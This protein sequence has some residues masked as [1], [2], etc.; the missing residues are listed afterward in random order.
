M[1]G[2]LGSST[3]TTLFFCGVGQLAV[4]IITCVFI[5]GGKEGPINVAVFPLF[6]AIGMV[7][8]KFMEKPALSEQTLPVTI[9]TQW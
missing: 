8:S 7:F 3:D 4:S 1:E 6:F 2:I 9:K 5:E